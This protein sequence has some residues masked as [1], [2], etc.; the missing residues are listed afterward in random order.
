MTIFGHKAK[1][2]VRERQEATLN[3]GRGWK[4]LFKPYVLGIAVLSIALFTWSLGYKM[5]RIHSGSDAVR[6]VLVAKLW[7]KPRGA[8]VAASPR[9]SVNAQFDSGAFASLTVN[10]ELP[11][12]PRAAVLR[13]AAETQLSSNANLNLSSRAPPIHRPF[14]A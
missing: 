7:V 3:A 13:S 1:A 12:L 11:H 9:T 2:G 14:F 6:Q 4:Q 5:E 10:Q 8:P